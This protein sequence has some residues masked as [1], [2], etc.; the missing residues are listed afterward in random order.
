MSRNS[1]EN[2]AQS[3]SSRWGVSGVTSLICG[4]ALLAAAYLGYSQ[5]NATPLAAD[6]GLFLAFGPSLLNGVI[7]GL[8]GGLAGGVFG[9]LIGAAIGAILGSFKP[10]R[11]TVATGTGGAV[12]G[13]ALGAIVLGVVCGFFGLV[14]ALLYAAV[15]YVSGYAVGLII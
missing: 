8:I 13:S 1:L 2:G 3:C 4:V 7:S 5:A 12:A 9:G 11:I 10:G 15:G 14:L 6:F